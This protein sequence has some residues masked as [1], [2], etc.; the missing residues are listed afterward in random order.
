MRVF[1]AEGKDWRLEQVSTG[2]PVDKSHHN[3]RQ[4]GGT[5]FQEET[6]HQATRVYGRWRGSGRRGFAT[7][8]GSGP[9]EEAAG[10]TLC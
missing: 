7:S 5:V 3:G 4:P 8:D 9:G 1:Q 10:K 6:N 2:L